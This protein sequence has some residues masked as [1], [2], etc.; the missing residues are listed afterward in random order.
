MHPADYSRHDAEY[1]RRGAAGYTGWNN[2]TAAAEYLAL[3]EQ[4]FS[5]PRFSQGWQLLEPG[6]RGRFL[7]V[8]GGP[9]RL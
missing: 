3:L 1:Q 2:A 4:V 8:G 9:A 7:A 5:A 6:W